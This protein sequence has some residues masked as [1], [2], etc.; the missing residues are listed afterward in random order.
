MH[1]EETLK[2]EEEEDQLNK[3]IE[4]HRANSVKEAELLARKK[5]EHNAEQRQLQEEEGARRS[6]VN[7]MV[8]Q[9]DNS[10]SP[11]K[12]VLVNLEGKKLIFLFYF[13]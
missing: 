13:M 6:L 7:H 9:T 1:L 10:L 4:F 11:M 3:N 8:K 5:E 2:I 12:D